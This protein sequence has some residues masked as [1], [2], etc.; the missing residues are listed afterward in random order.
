[1]K[2]CYAYIQALLIVF[3]FFSTCYAIE[4]KE[5][6]P[7]FQLSLE[8]VNSPS[9]PTSYTPPMLGKGLYD[10][11][12]GQSPLVTGQPRIIDLSEVKRLL[13]QRVNINMKVN[14]CSLLYSACTYGSE[15]VVDEILSHNPDINAL[16]ILNMT[17]LFV[18]SG[19][20]FTD[21]V[22][23][24]L[25]KDARTDITADGKMTALHVAVQYG[26]LGTASLLL[27]HDVSINAIDTKKWTPLHYACDKGYV[28]IAE[29]LIQKGADLE[30]RNKNGRT[31]LYY[32]K[33][34]KDSDDRN[35]LFNSLLHGRC[36]NISAEMNWGEMHIACI[37]GCIEIAEY[38]IRAGKDYTFT[39]N[40]G[41]TPFDY[42]DLNDKKRLLILVE[43]LKEEREIPAGKKRQ[44]QTNKQLELLDPASIDMKI[45]L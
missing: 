15:E 34:S 19:Q 1:M 17:A 5:N 20:G 43:K 26:H 29:L 37:T 42:L 39:D 23:K 31:P 16:N 33:N 30:A 12:V 35:R 27:E 22:K 11:C 41:K 9:T 8:L 6:R 2:Y 24:L 32:L 10:A 40:N 13:K 3:I 4:D 25:I 28:H 44:S 18:A 7:V 45:I 21:I 14:N 38:N 36:A